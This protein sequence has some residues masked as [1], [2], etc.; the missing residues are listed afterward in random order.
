MSVLGNERLELGKC[1]CG[2][3]GLCTGDIAGRDTFLESFVQ[4]IRLVDDGLCRVAFVFEELEALS[5]C[6]NSLV[7]FVDR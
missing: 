3:L 6:S 5:V 2:L 1:A 7:V 4:S